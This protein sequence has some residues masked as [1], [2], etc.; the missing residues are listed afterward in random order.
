VLKLKFQVPSCEVFGVRRQSEAATALSIVLSFEVW[1]APAERSG[2]FDCSESGKASGIVK[3]KPAP[4]A[5]LRVVFGSS[6]GA[7]ASE[8][9]SD[10]RYGCLS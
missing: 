6:S 4:A 7:P 9:H 8:K 10:Q 5:K 1:S 2:A 3:R